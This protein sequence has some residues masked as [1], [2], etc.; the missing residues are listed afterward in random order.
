[1]K[2]LAKI[3]AKFPPAKITMFTVVVTQYS[4]SQVCKL[5]SHITHWCSLSLLVGRSVEHL[6]HAAALGHVKFEILCRVCHPRGIK[7]CCVL[8]HQVGVLSPARSAKVF[9]LQKKTILYNNSLMM[10]FTCDLENHVRYSLTE[11]ACR[12]LPIPDN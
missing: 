2:C 7:L 11:V 8:V 10:R 5:V 6:F 12:D 3:F 4:L 9:D 1:M